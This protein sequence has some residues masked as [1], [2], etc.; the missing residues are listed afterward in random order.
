V[1]ADDLQ[2][3]VHQVYG[4]MADPTYLI[5]TDGRVAYYNMWTH[6]ATLHQA[7]ESLIQQGGRGVVK[8]SPDRAVRPLPAIVD[9][10]RA[11]RRG[12]VQSYLERELAAPGSGALLWL[13]HKA[14]PLLAPL[15]LRATPLPRVSRVALALAGPAVA[16]GA[17]VI[18]RRAEA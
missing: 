6:A 7:I 14:R 18:R 3:T 12:L 4:S 1:V 10:W 17:F 9:G 8:W 5:G 16:V 2:A 15:G 11:L 13:G